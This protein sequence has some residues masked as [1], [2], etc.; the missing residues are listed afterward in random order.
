MST[1][2]QKKSCENRH[3]KREARQLG[4]SVGD[5]TTDHRGR[6]LFLV[7]NVGGRSVHVDVDCT[8]VRRVSEMPIGKKGMAATNEARSRKNTPPATTPTVGVLERA[9][10]R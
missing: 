8:F 6:V 10:V 7:K 3:Q 2:E 1:R 5:A 9:T 4:T